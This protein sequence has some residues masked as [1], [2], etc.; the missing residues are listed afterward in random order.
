M[1]FYISMPF[2]FCFFF[3]QSPVKWWK[4]SVFLEQ[5]QWPQFSLMLLT[6]ALLS[7][8][9]IEECNPWYTSSFNINV[10]KQS[11]LSST[12]EHFRSMDPSMSVFLQ[13][14]IL[15]LA[16][17]MGKCVSQ[18][19]SMPVHRAPKCYDSGVLPFDFVIEAGRASWEPQFNPS[20]QRRASRSGSLTPE[21]TE[22]G[23]Y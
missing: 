6:T 8:W 3:L 10:G 23:F 17:T 22:L 18:I 20:S 15:S 21:L 14:M 4:L 9:R 1:I 16:H 5:L 13:R 19:F 2:H 7:G 11:S 12:P